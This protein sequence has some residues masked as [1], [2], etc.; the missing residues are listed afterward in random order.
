MLRQNLTKVAIREVQQSVLYGLVQT[1]LSAGQ[2][3]KHVQVLFLFLQKIL[4][5]TVTE[6]QQIRWPSTSNS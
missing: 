3:V 1:E 4:A 6:I 2:P 5:E